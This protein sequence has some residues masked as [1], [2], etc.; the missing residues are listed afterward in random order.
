MKY[1]IDLVE[2]R[3]FTETAKKNFVSQTT[4]SQQIIEY[5]ICCVHR[6]PKLVEIHS[7]I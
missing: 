7:F 2:C 3:N 6:Y 4:I 1:F 5:R